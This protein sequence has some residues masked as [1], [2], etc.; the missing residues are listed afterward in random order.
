[1]CFLR[2]NG[3]EFLVMLSTSNLALRIILFYIFFLRESPVR[4]SRLPPGIHV[5]TYEEIENDQPY[6]VIAVRDKRIILEQ[7]PAERTFQM[8]SRLRGRH[9]Y[10]GGAWAFPRKKSCGKLQ[11]L[12]NCGTS[13]GTGVGL[14][15]VTTSGRHVKSLD[16][17]GSAWSGV[18]CLC[19]RK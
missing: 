2:T 7:D 3:A 16:P 4:G 1:M 14:Q 11:W 19:V 15:G 10:S 6:H 9:E 12:C 5:R 13:A 17:V 8:F 18:A